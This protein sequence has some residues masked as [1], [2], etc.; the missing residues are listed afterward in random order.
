VLARRG[1]VM[2]MSRKGNCYD[3]AP[4]ESFFSSLKNE[5]V[6]HRQFQNQAEARYAI[7]EYI[8]RFYNRQRL[9]QTLGY[10]RPEEFERQENGA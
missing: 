1:V 7:A 5:L 3:N 10:R 8:E 6:R 2:R 9:H 4:V